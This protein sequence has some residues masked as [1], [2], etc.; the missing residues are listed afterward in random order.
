MSISCQVRVHN[1]LSLHLVRI[2]LSLLRD[3]QP[4]HVNIRSQSDT[5]FPLCD[6]SQSRFNGESLGRLQRENHRHVHLQ[7]LGRGHSY[8]EPDSGNAPLST[9]PSR[10]PR[11]PESGCAKV[12]Q[13]SATLQVLVPH[14]LN[15]PTEF[16]S[17]Q[18]LFCISRKEG[19][20]H[21]ELGYVTDTVSFKAFLKM[22]LLVVR[23]RYLGGLRLLQATC[24][25]FYQFCSK[26]G[27][28][29][30]LRQEE[31]N[32]YLSS[33][34]SFYKFTARKTN[35]CLSAVVLPTCDGQ[36]VFWQ[37]HRSYSDSLFFL[38]QIHFK[39]KSISP[40]DDEV[41]NTLVSVRW[42]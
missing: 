28:D 34:L 39:K 19:W 42:M 12:T 25:K 33:M 3:S 9:R 10:K 2:W 15:D 18:D 4:E 35:M 21:D 26:Q 7:L 13:I 40:E 22:F 1:L 16:G 36:I 5:L 6:G 24:K 37:K 38:V 14:P 17:L 23:C 8:R 11:S 27:W 20:V 41:K 32:I 30:Q 31:S 29:Q